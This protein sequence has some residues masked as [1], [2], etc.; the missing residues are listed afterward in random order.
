MRIVLIGPTYP[1]RGGI[2]HYN[3]CLNEQLR[4]N[5]ETLLIS[6]SKQYPKLLFPGQT[7][8]DLSENFLSTP[9]EPLL[10]PIRPS[11][12]YQVCTRISQ[13]K[14]EAVVF[15][16]WTPYFSPC[17]SSI[18]KRLSKEPNLNRI[19]LCHNIFPHE[20]PR[21]P[22]AYWL[23][24][25]MIKKVF[26]Q[27]DGFLVH[28]E[29]MSSQV[30]SYNRD[31]EVCSILHPVYDFFQKME[32]KR[33]HPKNQNKGNRIRLLFFGKIRAYKGLE[34]FL[35]ALVLL[36]ERG[37]HYRATV[38]GEFYI[39]DKPFKD[40]VEHQNISDQVVWHDH[41]IPNE[42]VSSLFRETDLV[43]L[44]YLDAT[45]SGVVPLAFGFC[46]PVVVSD[47]GSLGEVV[48]DGKTGYLVPPGDASALADSITFFS[49]DPNASLLEKNIRQI[50][51][52]F[53]WSQ[54]EA[55][56]LA[57]LGAIGKRQSEKRN[58]KVIH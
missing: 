57:L 4:Q 3:S 24:R 52:D 23:V 39:D 50:R 58:N 9:T 21:V 54:V 28:S 8:Q 35:R 32:K 11:S 33:Q 14:P 29:K 18:M 2:A 40:M 10:N 53:S 55:G 19:L 31:A 42:E 44:P 17:F 43:V 51:S 7:Q 41:Y 15:Q 12:W 22:G 1:F 48:E 47:V 56:L 6:L 13:F 37:V 38:A 16:W 20:I 27:A 26:R 49:Q 45:Q 46:K 5:H 34:V 30:S 25:R 36:K